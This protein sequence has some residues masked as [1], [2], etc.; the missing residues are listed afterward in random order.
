MTHLGPRFVVRIE[1]ETSVSPQGNHEGVR[2]GGSIAK[3]E[4]SGTDPSTTPRPLYDPFNL[5]VNGDRSLG[6][7]TRPRCASYQNHRGA[8][9]GFRSGKSKLRRRKAGSAG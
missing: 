1:R 2:R 6:R 8:P 4:K 5:L 3:E 7:K 9:L